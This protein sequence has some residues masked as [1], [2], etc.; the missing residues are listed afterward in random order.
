MFTAILVRLAAGLPFDTP[1]PGIDW[2]VATQDMIAEEKAWE[3][4]GEYSRWFDLV[5]LQKLEEVVAKRDPEEG[6]IYGQLKYFLP[7][8]DNM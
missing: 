5:R 7:I 8:P 6:Y 4:A 2:T 3:F 1:A